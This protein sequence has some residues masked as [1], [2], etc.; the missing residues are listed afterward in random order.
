MKS[1]LL[2][3]PS[4]LPI[5]PLRDVTNLSFVIL[6]LLVSAVPV[7]YPPQAMRHN[8][9]SRTLGGPVKLPVPPSSGTENRL[10]GAKPGSRVRVGAHAPFLYKTEIFRPAERSG[11][12]VKSSPNFLLSRDVEVFVLERGEG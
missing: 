2:M 5:Y 3:F 9:L 4:V 1:P 7:V 8:S 6:Q 11:A 10:V 12:S